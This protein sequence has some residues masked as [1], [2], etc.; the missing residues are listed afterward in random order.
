MIRHGKRKIAEEKQIRRRRKKYNKTRAC[1]GDVRLHEKYHVR[2]V[3][4]QSLRQNL[5]LPLDFR[6]HCRAHLLSRSAEELNRM[7]S[8]SEEK[9][10]S[11]RHQKVIL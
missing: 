5:S 9:G 2:V 11:V 8:E 4:S 3:M 10:Q 6:S 7:E 1:A